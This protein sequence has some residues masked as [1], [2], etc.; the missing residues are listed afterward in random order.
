MTIVL[1]GNGLTPFDEA[2][3]T[4]NAASVEVDIR[5]D[6]TQNVCL[7]M[8]TVGAASDGVYGR[9]QLLDSGGTAINNTRGKMANV[10]DTT[11]TSIWHTSEVSTNYYALGS[12]SSDS[13]VAGERLNF[14]LWINAAQN[15]SEPFFDVSAFGFIHVHG[16]GTVQYLSRNSW[17]YEG[18]AAPYKLK[19][20]FNSGNISTASLKSYII[21][22]D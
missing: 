5:D 4:T 3:V 20:F 22:S 10:G 1:G 7:V 6:A 12:A 17:Y 8:G 15:A 13:S 16:T 11:S 19:F 9:M 14:M 21:G 18:A 2:T